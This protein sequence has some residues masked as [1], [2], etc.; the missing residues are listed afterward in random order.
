MK[1][2]GTLVRVREES[3]TLTPAQEATIAMTAEIQAMGPDERTRDQE[4]C[5]TSIVQN[6]LRLAAHVKVMQ[7]EPE[8]LDDFRNRYGDRFTDQLQLVA[9]G[10][11]LPGLI[12]RFYT[13]PGL[14]HALTGMPMHVQQQLADGHKIGLLVLGPDGRPELRE[15]DPLKLSPEEI[16]QAFDK[17]HIRSQA[18]QIVHLDRE[19]MKAAK[20]VPDKVGDIRI[21]RGVRKAFFP[22][23]G[24]YHLD[25]LLAVVK[26]LQQ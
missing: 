5:I 4:R 25:E 8:K 2:N 21:D 1:N 12:H 6:I 23:R 14:L 13:K 24:G 11:L 3:V 18:E 10:M 26:A 20:P 15:R 16:R 7:D 19:R 17:N 22:R 9:C